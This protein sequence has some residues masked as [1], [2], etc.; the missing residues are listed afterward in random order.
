CRE[1]RWCGLRGI[2]WIVG[3]MWLKGLKKR[4]NNM[5]E[6]RGIGIVKSRKRKVCDF[7]LV[8]KIMRK[9]LILVVLLI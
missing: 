9:V 1:R 2:K 3:E 5:R 6:D 4:R 7:E 8:K